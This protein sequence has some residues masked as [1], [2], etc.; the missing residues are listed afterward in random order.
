MKNED[1]EWGGGKKC[2]KGLLRK[3]LQK[4]GKTLKRIFVGLQKIFAG[5]GVV[6][7]L[8]VFVWVKHFSKRGRGQ[9]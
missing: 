6:L 4:R 7:L 1:V 2:R 5:G 3:L 8:S 9:V